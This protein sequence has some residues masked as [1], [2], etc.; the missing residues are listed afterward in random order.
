MGRPFTLQRGQRYLIAR[1]PKCDEVVDAI[2]DPGAQ[3]SKD[4]EAEWVIICTDCGP[5]TLDLNKIEAETWFGGERSSRT[6][7]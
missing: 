3:R 7:L 4:G 1:C 5:D 6:R 2:R